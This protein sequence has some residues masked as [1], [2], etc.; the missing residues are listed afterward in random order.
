[1]AGRHRPYADAVPGLPPA[2]YAYLGPE[3]TFTEAAARQVPAADRSDLE[4]YASVPAALE[5][6]HLG[7]VQ[8]AVVPLENSVEGSV[9]AT[10]DELLSGEPLMI[11]REVVLPVEFVLLARAGTDLSDVQQVTTHPTGSKIGRAHV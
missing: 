7:D 6:V 5:A 9:N 1:M 2:R 10:L 3:G 8:G 4:P 11:T